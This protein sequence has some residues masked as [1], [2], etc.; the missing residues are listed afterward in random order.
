MKFMGIHETT[1]MASG[2]D[3][4]DHKTASLEFYKKRHGRLFDFYAVY[5]YFCDKNKPSSFCTKAE[6]DLLGKRPIGK[7]KTRQ[8]EANAKLAKA[9]IFEEVIKKEGGGVNLNHGNGGSNAGYGSGI[10]SLESTIGTGGM[11]GEVL[12][13]ISNVIANV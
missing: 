7:K 13:N 1:D 10:N 6:E 11:M 8:F 2:W 4:E 9:L 3:V 12:Q 5:E